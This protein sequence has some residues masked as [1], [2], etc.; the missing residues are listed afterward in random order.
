MVKSDSK[1][2]IGERRLRQNGETDPPKNDLKRAENEPLLNLETF[3]R[4]QTLGGTF[5]SP[6]MTTGTNADHF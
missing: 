2:D 6:E 1:M 5:P 3:S 4:F